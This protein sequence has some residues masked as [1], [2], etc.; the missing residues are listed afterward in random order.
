MTAVITSYSPFS[1]PLIITPIFFFEKSK[2]LI[3]LIDIISETDNYA[4][5]LKDNIIKLNLLITKKNQT[6]LWGHHT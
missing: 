3:I 4:L 5:V 6:V 2:N 1:E